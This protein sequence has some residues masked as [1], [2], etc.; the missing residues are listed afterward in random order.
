[1]ASPP[2][3]S[4]VSFAPFFDRWKLPATVKDDCDSFVR[5]RYSQPIQP[6]PFQGYCSYTLFVGE[7]TVVQFRPLAH[8]LDMIIARTACHVFGSMAP[9]T[10]YL[11]QLMDTGLCAFS[12]RKLPGVSLTDFR[13]VSSEKSARERVIQDFAHLQAQAWHHAK[14]AKDLLHEKRTVGSTLRW[15]LES[16]SDELPLSIRGIARS[17]LAKLSDIEALPWVFSHGDF[18]P[19]NVMVSP[20]SGKLLGLL[21]W[22]EA[23]WLPFGVGMYGLEE[24]LGEDEDGRFVY[25]PEAKQLRGLFW[26]S[27]LLLVPELARGSRTVAHV[28]DAQRLGILLWHGIAFDDGKLDRVVEEGKD[29]QE[30]QRL[31][32]FLLHTS[33]TRQRKLRNISPMIGSPLTLIRSLLFGKA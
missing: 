16:M 7:D 27:L 31:T 28:K 9:E 18:L 8:K 2:R 5:S 21:D 4:D 25:Y 20:Y 10:E 23:E 15:R 17:I 29:D 3:D 19:A 1:M 32:M 12:M 13:A 11:G 22:A 6:A 14:T 30:I 26:K 33:N 24:L